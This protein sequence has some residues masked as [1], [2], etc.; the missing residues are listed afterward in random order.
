MGRG[1]YYQ[2]LHTYA[3]QDRSADLLAAS[4]QYEAL[5]ADGADN[6][7][8]ALFSVQQGQKV[9]LRGVLLL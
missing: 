6:D 8:N 9:L 1:Y 3:L 7:L 4:S 2:I 5:G